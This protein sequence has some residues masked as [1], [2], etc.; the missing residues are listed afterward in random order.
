MDVEHVLGDVEDHSLREELRSCQHF[1]VDSQLL[2]RARHK[3]ID[4]AKENLNA[5]IVQEKLDHFFNNLKF[6]AKVNVAFGFV[7]TKIED[8]GLRYFYAHQKLYPAGS[9]Q[10]FMHQGRLGEAKK[11]C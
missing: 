10:T 8:E 2:E 1:L 9:I 3:V 11:Y 4:Y 7:L 5:E 6:A